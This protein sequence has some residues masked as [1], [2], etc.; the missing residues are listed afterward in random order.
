MVVMF[1]RNIIL[2][3]SISKYLKEISVSVTSESGNND[4]GRVDSTVFTY[5]L[6]FIQFSKIRYR[7]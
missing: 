3:C 7:Y 6:E 5:D 1:L 2:Y 4:S